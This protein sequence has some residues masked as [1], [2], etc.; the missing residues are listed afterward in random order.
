MESWELIWHIYKAK[1]RPNL[2]MLCAII[3]VTLSVVLFAFQD[4]VMNI[5]V[6]YF[7]SKDSL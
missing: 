6:L 7:M 4:A 5:V 3:E 2:A 1:R